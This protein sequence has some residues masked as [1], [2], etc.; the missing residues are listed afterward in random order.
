MTDEIVQ[1]LVFREDLKLPKGKAVAQAG[2]AVA[3]VLRLVEREG[4]VQAREWLRD[5]EA[6]S[7]A[8]IALKIADLAALEALGARLDAAGLR[9]VTVVDEG[10]NVVA[11]DTVTVIG[12]A[13]VPRSMAQPFVEGLRLL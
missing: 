11:P 5:W 3:L 8:K 2:H 12:L 9:Y 7:S 13:P 6:G 4:S 10:R 1:Y